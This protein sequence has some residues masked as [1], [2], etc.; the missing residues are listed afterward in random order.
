MRGA[1]RVGGGGSC[2]GNL[3]TVPRYPLPWSA[4]RTRR[5][6]PHSTTSRNTSI[7]PPHGSP[8][9]QATSSEI[10]YERSLGSPVS[11]TS[12]AFSNTSLSTHPPDTEPHIFPD[13]EMARL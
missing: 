7:S 9:L 3:H 8:T 2:R 1:R 10:P 11:S 5:F 12:C 4:S 6:A 13:S